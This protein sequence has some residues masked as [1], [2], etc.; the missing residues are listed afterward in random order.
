MNLNCNCDEWKKGRKALD[1][2]TVFAWTH[3]MK[4]TGGPFKFCPWC[5][6]KLIDLDEENHGSS[7]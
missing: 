5:G 2:I 4:Y 1:S 6:T 7:V 3:G